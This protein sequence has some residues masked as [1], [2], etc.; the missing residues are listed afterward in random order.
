MAQG[1]AALADGTASGTSCSEDGVPR[2]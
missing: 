2:S 1:V